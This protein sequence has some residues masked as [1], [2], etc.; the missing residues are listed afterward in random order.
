MDKKEV[1]IDE[2]S[3]VRVDG[4]FAFVGIN[5]E[6]AK[7][8]KEFVFIMMPEL[9]KE[10]KKGEDYVSVEAVKW[11]GHIK[12]PVSGVVVEVNEELYDEP[13]KINESPYD[14]WIMKVKLNDAKEIVKK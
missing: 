7:K 4:E 9:N 13:S 2:Q 1:Y 8:V 10:I 11:S 3:W 6:A 12:S 5:E 14:S